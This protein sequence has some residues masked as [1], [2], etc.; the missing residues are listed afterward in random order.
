MIFLFIALISS[1]TILLAGMPGELVTIDVPKIDAEIYSSHPLIY[2]SHT[3][4]EATFQI[5][6]HTKQKVHESYIYFVEENDES[7]RA[8]LGI[9][10]L[11]NITQAQKQTLRKNHSLNVLS[12][13]VSVLV[14]LI[15]IRNVFD[16]SKAEQDNHEE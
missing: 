5:E 13:L 7:I 9:S 15:M 14:I 12:V 16:S 4:G 8:G 2:V 6:H 3:S 10:A 11:V 1:E